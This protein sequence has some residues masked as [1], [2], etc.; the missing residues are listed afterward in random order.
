MV[1]AAFLPREL[2][3]T[4]RARVHLAWEVFRGHPNGL[5]DLSN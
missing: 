3:P 2:S 1:E 4:S 5:C